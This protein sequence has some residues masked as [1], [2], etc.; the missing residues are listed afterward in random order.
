MIGAEAEGVRARDERARIAADV[1]AFLDGGGRI[2]K[3]PPGV[4]GTRKL[5]HGEH[6]DMVTAQSRERKGARAAKRLRPSNG[7][8]KR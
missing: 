4:T 5:K 1:R 2:Q 8:A 7:T 3:V 6:F